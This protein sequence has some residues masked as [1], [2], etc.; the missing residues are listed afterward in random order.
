MVGLVQEGTEQQHVPP[1][2]SPKHLIGT[3]RETYIP[4]LQDPA[5]M[6]P[7]FYSSPHYKEQLPQGTPSI[8]NQ[9]ILLSES[10]HKRQIIGLNIC[11]PGIS[12]R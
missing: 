7:W 4:E 11:I 5:S 6:P 1:Q 12:L 3:Q 10:V 2:P 8:C 9:R